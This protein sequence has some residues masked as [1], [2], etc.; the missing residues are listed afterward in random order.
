MSDV[1]FINSYNEIVFDNFI[2]VL[3]QN[4]VFQTQLKLM[5]PK[6]ARI[7]ELEQQVA[8]SGTTHQELEQLRSTVQSLT[9]ELTGKNAQIQQQSGSDAERHRIQTALNEKMRECESLKASVE[10]LNRE[11]QSLHTQAKHG[12]EAVEMNRTLLVSEQALQDTVQKQ[13]AYIQKLEEMLPVNKRKKLGLP[14][15]DATI[16]TMENRSVIESSGGIF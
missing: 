14:V 16:N 15:P 2:A 11:V 8:D 9:S 13:T 1:N 6:L 10:V 7:A 12:Q 5:E 4:M 3:K